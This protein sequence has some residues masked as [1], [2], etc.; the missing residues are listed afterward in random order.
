MTY[1]ASSKMLGGKIADLYDLVE[2][3]EARHESLLLAGKMITSAA[4]EAAIAQ[5]FA[6]AAENL[7]VTSNCVPEAL[8]PPGIDTMTEKL[9]SGGLQA[10]RVDLVK[11]YKASLEAMYLR[12]TYKFGVDTA[13]QRLGHIKTMVRDDCVEAKIAKEQPNNAYAGAMYEDLRKR[14]RT[15]VKDN[16]LPLFGCAE[17][18]LLGAAGMLTEEC[19]VWWSDT[20]ELKSK[21]ST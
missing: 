7:L 2:D 6:D 8:L 17:E 9:A 16:T 15:R 1:E 4:V 20:F 10:E 13:N 3:Y 19:K 12:W 5:S 11:D 21:G 18:H 14:L